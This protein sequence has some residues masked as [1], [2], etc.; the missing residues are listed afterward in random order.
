MSSKTSLSACFSI[1]KLTLI[2]TTANKKFQT[3]NLTFFIIF[4]I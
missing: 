4:H 1:Y 3:G 2:P